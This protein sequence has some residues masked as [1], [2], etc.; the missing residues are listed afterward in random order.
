MV[1]LAN[2]YEQESSSS[3]EDDI[4]IIQCLKR[5]AELGDAE[6]QYKLGKWRIHRDIHNTAQ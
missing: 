2:L 5:A 3:E 4:R 6:G 1:Q